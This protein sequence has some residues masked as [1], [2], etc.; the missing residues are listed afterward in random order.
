MGA[1]GSVACSA[2]LPASTRRHFKV[3]QAPWGND[4]IADHWIAGNWIADN[5]IA[6]DWIAYD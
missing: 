6:H 1:I 4:W 3:A 5:A 2:V